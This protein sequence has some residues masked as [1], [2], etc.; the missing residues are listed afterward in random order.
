MIDISFINLPHTHTQKKTKQIFFSFMW[1]NSCKLNAIFYSKLKNSGK[2]NKKL[3]TSL[4]ITKLEWLI[5]TS[6]I[7]INILKS[8]CIVL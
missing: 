1:W 4:P 2:I 6:V 8:A 3:V 7:D 5:L